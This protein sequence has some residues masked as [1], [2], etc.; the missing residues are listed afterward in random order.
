MLFCCEHT[1]KSHQ[2]V[3]EAIEVVKGKPSDLPS[4]GGQ[5][6]RAFVPFA[7]IYDKSCLR[8]AIKDYEKWM[9][10]AKSKLQEAEAEMSKCKCTE[11]EKKRAENERKKAENER[12]KVDNLNQ[13]IK[14]KN[15][16]IKFGKDQFS[17]KAWSI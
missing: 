1:K 7:S 5:F 3:E 6:F 12:T 4:K 10:L 14:D 16:F 13:R 2:L 8:D 11:D 15:E 17:R 9:S